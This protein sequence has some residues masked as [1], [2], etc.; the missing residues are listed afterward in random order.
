MERQAF[1]AVVCAW[2]FFAVSMKLDQ[3]LFYR[4]ERDIKSPHPTTYWE[5]VLSLAFYI[6]TIL[7]VVSFIMAVVG[8]I[9]LL[10]G[11]FK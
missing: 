6:V 7:T 10:V 5:V 11:T 3:I 2:C 1:I 4:N 9:G 8:T